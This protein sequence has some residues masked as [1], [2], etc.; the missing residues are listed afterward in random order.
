M[1]H[2]WLECQLV[3][4]FSPDI[5][6]LRLTTCDGRSVCFS[7]SF[8]NPL[9]WRSFLDGGLQKPH[10]DQKSAFTLTVPVVRL[11]LLLCSCIVRQLPQ[12]M[13][14]P[15]LPPPTHIHTH[16][17]YLRCFGWCLERGVQTRLR[18]Q[19]NRS[20]SWTSE[21]LRL[22]VVW[23]HRHTL[24]TLSPVGVNFPLSFSHTPLHLSNTETDQQTW[25]RTVCGPVGCCSVE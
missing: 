10:G 5:L 14:P 19:F 16:C 3:P 11:T 9:F 4:L 6:F 12:R 25:R 24:F 7:F 1:W 21:G 2:R 13:P 17:V 18:L 22:K 8:F 20:G 23:T 15:H